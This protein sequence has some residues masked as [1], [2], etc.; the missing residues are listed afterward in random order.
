LRGREHYRD[1]YV[2]TRRERGE[3]I[4]I[5]GTAEEIHLVAGDVVMKFARATG[6]LVGVTVGGEET[7]FG[8]GP[9]LVGGEGALA[10]VELSKSR[11]S[12]L[13]RVEYTGDLEYTR[14]RL[15][16]TGWA[17]L[18][19]RYRLEGA[20][21]AFGVDFEFPEENMRRMRW[22]G[23][24]PFR[25]WK[26]RM[27]GGRLDVWGNAYKDHTPGLTWDFPEFRGYYRDWRWVVFETQTGDITMVNESKDAFLGVYRPQDGPDPKGTKL[28][29]P[30]TGI[31]LLHGIPAIGTKFQKPEALGPESQK[32]N[33]SGTYRGKVW[34]RFGE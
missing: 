8:G 24:G 18:E 12:V 26:N 4:R 22:L 34:F 32:N 15:Y 31:A 7:A 5:A 28:D 20:F 9:R 27:K 10:K 25:V 30:Q 19:Y 3:R 14:W 13:L 17:S 11:D 29:A 6:G 23:R 16:A 2:R 21:A 33:A 1:R